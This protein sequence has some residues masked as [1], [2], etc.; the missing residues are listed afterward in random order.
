MAFLAQRDDRN[1]PPGP[2][3]PQYPLAQQVQPTQSTNSTPS[4]STTGMP[5]SHSVPPPN[6][7]GQHLASA[8]SGNHS[9][10]EAVADAQRK[11]LFDFISPYEAL[12]SNQSQSQLYQPPNQPLNSPPTNV[13]GGPSIAKKKPG[14]CSVSRLRSPSSKSVFFVVPAYNP[15]PQQIAGST[16]ASPQVSPKQSQLQRRH[17]P[18]PDPGQYAGYQPGNPSIGDNYTESL[19][20]D[21][22]VPPPPMANM[23][24]PPLEPRSL[25]TPPGQAPGPQHGP[26]PP[27]PTQQQPQQ[28]SSPV[29]RLAQQ[30]QQP[31]PSP[32][33]RPS[34]PGP[35][36]STQRAPTPPG[37]RQVQD[38]AQQQLQGQRSRGSPASTRQANSSNQPSSRDGASSPAGSGSGSSGKRGPKPVQ[39]PAAQTYGS[40]GGQSGRGPQCVPSA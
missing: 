8:M 15:S 16:N 32:P 6:T 24:E 17:T 38:L 34:H 27:I 29:Q 25:P 26:L 3:A 12:Q 31:L 30:V 7:H 11:A 1:P 2:Q 20:V 39:Q 13:Q 36:N 33:M 40:P 35:N 9:D 37:Q 5:A 18:S 19:N 4:T 14:M 22:G 21:N 23:P 28:Q 10:R